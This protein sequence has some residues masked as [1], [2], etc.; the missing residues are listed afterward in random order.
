MTL[1]REEQVMSDAI[2]KLEDGVGIGIDKDE[3]HNELFNR[4]YFIIGTYQAKQ[5]LGDYAFDAIGDIQDYENDNF[6]EV[7]TDLSSPEKVVNMWAYIVGEKALWNSQV[8]RNLDDGI[9]TEDDV[10]ELIEDLNN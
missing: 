3:L 4:D 9:L 7:N 6:G 1:N 8:F 2:S 10:K 5:F